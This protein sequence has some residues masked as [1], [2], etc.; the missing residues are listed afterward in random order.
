MPWLNQMEDKLA[1]FEPTAFKKKQLEKQLRELQQIR[2][3]VWKKYVNVLLP[4]FYFC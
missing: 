2:N 4:I 3:D 1:K